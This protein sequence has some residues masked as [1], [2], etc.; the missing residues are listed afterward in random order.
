M[1]LFGMG[2]FDYWSRRANQ[3]GTL[4]AFTLGFFIVGNPRFTQ[5]VFEIAG[6]KLSAKADPVKSFK[7]AQKDLLSSDIKSYLSTQFQPGISRGEIRAYTNGL[8][9]YSFRKMNSE[10]LN[11]RD[12]SF[13]ALN[14]RAAAINSFRR[15][16]IKSAS[17]LIHPSRR[18]PEGER[19]AEKIFE[20]MGELD[21]EL[22]A[23]RRQQEALLISEWTS[24]HDRYVA[25][26]A[27]PIPLKDGHIPISSFKSMKIA[28]DEV[29]SAK[30]ILEDFRTKYGNELRK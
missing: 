29:D 21:L 17:M 20:K 22:R 15:E 5:F 30:K 12:L 14:T 3:M 18:S 13:K 2:I 4:F 19:E 24:A 26:F 1:P 27:R 16:Q 9:K 6:F 7:G 28:Q 23:I 11:L 25:S 10:N 8:K